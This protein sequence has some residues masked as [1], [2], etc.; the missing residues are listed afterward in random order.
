MAKRKAPVNDD[1]IRVV[2]IGDL[3]Y[4]VI[5]SLGAQ[6]IYSNQ[7]LGKLPEPYKGNLVEDIF[8][9]YKERETSG[10]NIEVLLGLTWAMA[11]ARKSVGCGFDEFMD[12]LDDKCLTIA[13]VAVLYDDIVNGMGD[14]FFR[15]PSGQ[16]DAGEPDSVK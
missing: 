7:F 16:D 6:V 8:A 4:E 15:L 14:F 11:R 13:E 12:A 10:F 3:E 1:N 5:G 2:H 9:A